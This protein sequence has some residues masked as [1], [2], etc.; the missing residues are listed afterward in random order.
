[1]ATEK[2]RVNEWCRSAGG[3]LRAWVES[4]G[5][6]R[7]ELSRALGVSPTRV[8]RCLNPDHKDFGSP[9]FVKMV[10]DHYPQW[11]QLWLEYRAIEDGI[12]V[13]PQEQAAAADVAKNLAR[14]RE[15]KQVV[16]DAFDVIISEMSKK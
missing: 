1:M 5:P 10:Q 7:A 4:S 12:D 2:N 6:S 13:D 14:V 11:R 15:L 16:V 8:G 3:A 9:A